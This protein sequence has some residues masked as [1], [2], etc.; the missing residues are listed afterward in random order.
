MPH[1]RFRAVEESSVAKISEEMVE[2]LSFALSCPEDY[3]SFEWIPSQFY[4]RGEKVSGV[5][6]VE[7]IWFE[8]GQDQRDLIAQMLHEGLLA[9]G[10]EESTIIF[11]AAPEEAYYDNGQH[12]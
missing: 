8:R 1:L 10:Y 3:F 12:Y 7:I 6:T 11:T 5:P 9:L 2:A 4:F